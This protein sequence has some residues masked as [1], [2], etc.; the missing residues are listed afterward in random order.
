MPAPEREYKTAKLGEKSPLRVA[1][2]RVRG[3]GDQLEGL[4]PF[5]CVSFD[6]N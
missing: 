3:N 2:S 6:E 4:L 5:Q 1:W